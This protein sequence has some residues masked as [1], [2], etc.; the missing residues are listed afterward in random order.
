MNSREL[1]IGNYV[2]VED[3]V[4]EVVAIIDSDENKIRVR[5]GLGPVIEINSDMANPIILTTDFLVS[6][7]HF[8]DM[9]RHILGIDHHRY[10]LRFYDGYILLSDKRDEPIIHFWDVRHLHQLQNLYHALKGKEIE[11][12]FKRKKHQLRA[13]VIQR[14]ADRLQKLPAQKV[15]DVQAII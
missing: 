9:G 3:E 10:F 14:L 6:H 4:A 15:R 1:R 13:C 7:C 8:D 2:E 11:I 5:I 12:D